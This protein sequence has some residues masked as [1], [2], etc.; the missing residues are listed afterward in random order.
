MITLPIS[1]WHQMASLSFDQIK[2][3]RLHGM[4]SVN[5]ISSVLMI[6]YHIEFITT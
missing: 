1:Q 4:D 3:N 6:Y 2:H 5:N